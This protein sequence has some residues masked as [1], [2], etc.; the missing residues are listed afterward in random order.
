[1]GGLLLFNFGTATIGC[2]LL[3]QMWQPTHE[4]HSMWHY[5]CLCAIKGER[6]VW[7]ATL[8]H[9]A[10]QFMKRC[11]SYNVTLY[12]VMLSHAVQTDGRTSY[13][14]VVERDGESL[15]DVT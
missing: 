5:N 1:M 14:C 3:Y 9:D 6:V 13:M 8:L 7:L 15:M 12:Q 4:L 2:S 10:D 11:C